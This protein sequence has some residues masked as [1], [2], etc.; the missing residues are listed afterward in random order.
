MGSSRVK[1]LLEHESNKALIEEKLLPILRANID[2][3]NSLKK[4][5]ACYKASKGEDY[6]FEPCAII[7]TDG[8]DVINIPE[9]IISYNLFRRATP[10]D[11]AKID[12][13][14]AKLMDLAVQAGCFEALVYRSLE[15]IKKIKDYQYGSELFQQ[16]HMQLEKINKE[17]CRLYRGAGYI[18]AGINYLCAAEAV[19]Q[20]I[21]NDN[22]E[23]DQEHLLAS[24]IPLQDL[25]L[26]YFMCAQILENDSLSKQIFLSVVPKGNVYN[27]FRSSPLKDDYENAG[28][29][30][31]SQSVKDLITILDKYK[32]G[33]SDTIK[34][35]AE[36]E[37]AA[38]KQPAQSTISNEQLQAAVKL[39]QLAETMFYKPVSKVIENNGMANS[40]NNP[41]SRDVGMN[42]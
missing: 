33:Y 31:F 34:L 4:I 1:S 30:I 14:T 32:P 8:N 2:N 29:D 28:V 40:S 9:Q 12:S 22:S 17:L 36:Q 37:I 7:S 15:I 26:K 16:A 24:I 6:N 41:N 5:I 21:K 39:N 11:R 27:L 13:N 42:K 10:T 35:N 18:Q 3:P 38:F 23:P 25:A 20:I 19:T